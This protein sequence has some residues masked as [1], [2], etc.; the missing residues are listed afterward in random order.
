M[1]RETARLSVRLERERKTARLSVRLGRERKTARFLSFEAISGK[2]EPKVEKFEKKEEKR[3]TEK[4]FTHTCFEK[5]ATEA[6]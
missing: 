5:T 4:I 2:I 6:V 3:N 1:G